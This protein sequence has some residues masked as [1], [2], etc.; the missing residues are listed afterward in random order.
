[1][2]PTR[3]STLRHVHAW[4]LIQSTLALAVQLLIADNPLLLLPP[5]V[6][7]LR[8]PARLRCARDL[9]ALCGELMDAVRA[10]RALGP[11]SQAAPTDTVEQDDIRLD[12]GE[13]E[14][15]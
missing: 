3:L 5:E 9:V 15:Q 10:Y 1:M 11:N 8:P 13:H 14:A 2:S 6:Q 7:V 12:G 4:S